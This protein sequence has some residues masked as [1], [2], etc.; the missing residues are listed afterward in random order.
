MQSI[1]VLLI[2]D[3]TRIREMIKDYLENEG[4]Q[5]LEAENGSVGLEKFKASEISIIILDVM[6]PGIDGWTVCKEIRKNSNVPII[7]LTARS[8]EYDK[9]FGFELGADDYLTKPFSPKELVA[10][11]KAVLKRGKEIGGIGNNPSIFEYRDL[12]VNLDSRKVT[13]SGETVAMTPKEFEL[14]SFLVRHPEKVFTREQLLNK[15]WGYEFGGDYRTVDTHIKMLR[16]SL[17]GYRNIIVTVWGVG[18]KLEV[19]VLK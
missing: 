19:E 1:N 3:E 12:L 6:L 10:R 13:L 4:F 14:L 2:E 7:M 17:K 15:V 8:E 11:M 9:L 16:E 18:Y 5:V